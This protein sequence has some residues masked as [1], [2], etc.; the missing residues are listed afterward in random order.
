MLERTDAE[1][2]REALGAL[3]PATRPLVDAA[4]RGSRSPP[5]RRSART[6][7]S[8]SRRGTTCRRSS[9][10]PTHAPAGAGG[11]A[12][13]PAKET[14]ERLGIPVLQ[15]DRPDRGARPRCG[16]RRR[17]RVRPADPDR[18]AR[19]A[20]VAQRPPVPSPALARRRTGRARAHGGRRRDGRHD[21]RDGRRAGRRPDRGP[22]GVPDR[23]TRTT[24]APS[25]SAPPRLRL[26]SSTTCSRSRRRRS[27]RRSGEP[28]YA[29][30][31]GPDDRRARARP[32]RRGARAA[33]CARSARTSA[34]ARSS[35]A[36]G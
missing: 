19:R 1:S 13:P 15:P 8:A 14:A 26:D 16:D 24:R 30:K 32:P 5:P 12:A 25:S 34:R 33:S 20:A 23:A 17:L 27:S 22:R 18:P 29:A 2:R 7:W 3:R 31:L 11:V 36:G 10:G 9:P 35:R 4:W 28:T 6:C 21:P